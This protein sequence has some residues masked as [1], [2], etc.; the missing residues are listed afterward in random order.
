[1]DR[2]K[3]LDHDW[4]WGGCG[5][6]I[7]YGYEFALAFVDLREN[8]SNH[9]KGSEE[10]AVMLMNKHNNEAGRRVCTLYLDDNCILVYLNY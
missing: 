6:N 8:E 1:M 3:T 7:K 9:P 10:L 4:V 2:P 5:D